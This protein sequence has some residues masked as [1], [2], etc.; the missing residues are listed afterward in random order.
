MYL[1]TKWASFWSLND[2]SGS[3]NALKKNRLEF[4]EFELNFEFPNFA[5]SEQLDLGRNL[6]ALC[7]L[8]LIVNAK[9]WLLPLPSTAP[10]R[11]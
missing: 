11:A 7:P 10:A 3:C 6:I 5:D 8:Y 1:V 9:S 4:L 2:K